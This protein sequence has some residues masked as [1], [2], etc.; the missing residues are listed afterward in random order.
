MHETKYNPDESSVVDE[1]L[2]ALFVSVFDVHSIGAQNET[3]C[4]FYV[5]I[6]DT[7]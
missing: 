5:D 4:S 7:L 3:Y 6:F 1:R 2:L